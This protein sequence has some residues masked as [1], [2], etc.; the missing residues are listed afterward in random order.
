MQYEEAQHLMQ[1]FREHRKDDGIE[2]TT[3]SHL[4][5]Q[6]IKALCFCHMAVGVQIHLYKLIFI[7]A[8]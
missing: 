6:E 1:L 3:T 4:E 7:Q 5:M 8:R 2:I